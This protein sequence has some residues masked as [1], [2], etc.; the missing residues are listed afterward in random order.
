MLIVST[1][2]TNQ[3]AIVLSHTSCYS[4]PYAIFG[5]LQWN[6]ALFGYRLGDPQADLGLGATDPYLIPCRRCPLQR[7]G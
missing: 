5:R 4:N 1:V 7:V 3:T 6:D 2:P